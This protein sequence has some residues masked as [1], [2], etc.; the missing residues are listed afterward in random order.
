[1]KIRRTLLNFIMIMIGG[2]GMW[3]QTTFEKDVFETNS[4]KL[5]IT[6]IGHGSLL[7]DLNGKTIYID[8]CSQY[9]DYSKMPK[10]DVI[11][12]TH[13]HGDHLDTNAIASISKN[14]T[15]IISSPT[16]FEQLKKGIAL[17]N[18][19]KKVVDGIEIEAF[20]AYN[21]TPG[22]DRFHP[23]GRDNGYILNLGGK[24]IYVAGDTENIPEMATLKDIDIAFLPMNQPYTML[25]EQVADA[26]S[27]FN[28]KI[29]Y[30]YH[31]GNTNV[32]ELVKMLK[33]KKNIEVRIRKLS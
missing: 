30:P 28:P 4:G 8:P 18:G 12:I 3:G 19:D 14:E 2:A 22:R 24:R 32:D 23:K 21:T 13:H 7:F 25:P 29:L 15:Q 20:P 6:F 27:K 16:A 17:K 10:A 26:V 31:Y 11:M 33:D 1:M 5:I 9:G